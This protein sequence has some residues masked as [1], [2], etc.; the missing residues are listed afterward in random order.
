MND[1]F[2]FLDRVYSL[3]GFTYKLELSTRPEGFLGKLEDWEKAEAVR[4]CITVYTVYALRIFLIYSNL[5]KSSTINTRV[6]GR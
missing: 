5:K 3:F 2:N 6:A 4:I 1:L